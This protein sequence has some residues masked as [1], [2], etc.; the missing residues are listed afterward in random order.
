MTADLLALLDRLE[1]VHAAATP[2][3]WVT[4]VSG[5]EQVIAPDDDH[6]YIARSGDLSPADAA[7]IAGGD[8]AGERVVLGVLAA[9]EECGSVGRF[10]SDW[11]ADLFGADVLVIARGQHAR[12]SLR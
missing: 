4:Y 1:A 8:Q 6:R 10:I 2:G 9:V 5:W 7:A 11:D 12:G 3:P